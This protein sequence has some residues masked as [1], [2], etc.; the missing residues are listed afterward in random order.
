MLSL[1]PEP[2]CQAEGATPAPLHGAKDTVGA[3][4]VDEA[5]RT[6]DQ[7]TSTSRSGRPVGAALQQCRAARAAALPSMS[8]RP[9]HGGFELG[10]APS[11]AGGL[12]R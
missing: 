4:P 1:V 3:G 6:P 10:N 7:D 5:D 12:L 9:G 2:R 8:M 11:P